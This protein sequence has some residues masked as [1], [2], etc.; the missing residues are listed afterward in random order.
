MRGIPFDVFSVD[1]S[2]HYGYFLSGELPFGRV[3][4]Y[5][6]T[7]SGADSCAVRLAGRRRHAD[8]AGIVGFAPVF[9][10]NSFDGERGGKAVIKDVP[11]PAH[12]ITSAAGFYNCSAIT[13]FTESRVVMC[14]G[15][16]PPRYGVGVRKLFDDLTEELIAAASDVDQFADGVG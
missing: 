15:K 9:A 4:F 10:V 13:D 1:A 5:V 12:F 7:G 14:A 6:A 3:R 11:Q 8:V 2:M 16:N